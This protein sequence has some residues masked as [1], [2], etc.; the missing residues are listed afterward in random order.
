MAT[1]YHLPQGNIKSDR[2][3]W[4]LLLVIGTAAYTVQIRRSAVERGLSPETLHRLQ[5]DFISIPKSDKYITENNIQECYFASFYDAYHYPFSLKEYSY[6]EIGNWRAMNNQRDGSDDTEDV[7]YIQFSL[8]RTEW[9]RKRAQQKDPK[10]PAVQR[11]LT[12]VHVGR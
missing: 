10:L 1:N 9:E 7:E 2:R 12:Y 5:I 6:V 3:L 8:K 11:N 4:V